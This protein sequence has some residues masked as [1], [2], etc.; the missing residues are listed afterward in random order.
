MKPGY[1]GFQPS[2]YQV[3]GP[4]QEPALSRLIVTGPA[5]ATTVH[6]T[7]RFT[8]RTPNLRCRTRVSLTLEITDTPTNTSD[9]DSG[10]VLATAAQQQAASAG[11]LWIAQ[12][13]YTKSGVVVPS[14]VANVVGTGNAPLAIPTDS[15]L[16]G[17]SVET[18][19]NG[20][21]LYGRFVPPDLGAGNVHT[22]RWCLAVR[23]ESVN[24]L[25]DEEWNQLRQQYRLIVMPEGG[26]TLS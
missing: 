23:Y 22:I 10:L 5:S 4:D 2:S 3:I 24:R 1:P 15:Q 17:Y 13:E 20:Q 7:V 9:A 8:V 19:T 12:R 18:E 21:E 14:V 16:W 26:V 25:G 6:P 11:T